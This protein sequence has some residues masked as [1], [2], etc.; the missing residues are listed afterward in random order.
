[1]GVMDKFLNIMRVND[2]TDYDFIRDNSEFK[3]LIKQLKQTD[4]TL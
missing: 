1:M 3:N 4:N 2:D